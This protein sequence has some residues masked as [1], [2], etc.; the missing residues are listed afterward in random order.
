MDLLATVRLRPLSQT[1][2]VMASVDG[3]LASSVIEL[4]SII[5]LNVRHGLTGNAIQ[6]DQACQ[7]KRMHIV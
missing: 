7:L 6:S 3:L 2:G 5:E 1:L 4:V